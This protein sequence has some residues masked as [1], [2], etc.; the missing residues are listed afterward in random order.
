VAAAPIGAGGGNREG[1]SELLDEALRLLALKVLKN[2]SA[3][4]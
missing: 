4:D 1:E 2:T 3:A